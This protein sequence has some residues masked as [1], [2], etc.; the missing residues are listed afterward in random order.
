MHK[1]IGLIPDRTNRSEG[2]LGTFDELVKDFH[3]EMQ[4]LTVA[5]RYRIRLHVFRHKL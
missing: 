2:R 1:P 3:L 4:C 5:C